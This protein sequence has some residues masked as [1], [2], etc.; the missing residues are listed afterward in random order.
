[1]NQFVDNA[2][3]LICSLKAFISGNGL[4][5]LSVNLL[6]HIGNLS[7]HMPYSLALDLQVG[8]RYGT[9]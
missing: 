4:L 2:Q 6:L 3:P 5:L 8:R 9:E 1:M 7:F